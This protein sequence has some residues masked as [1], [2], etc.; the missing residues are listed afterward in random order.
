MKL[1]QNKL[2]CICGKKGQMFLIAAIFIIV[3][4]A[5]IKTS[6]N[7]YQLLEN[8]RYLESSLEKEEFQNFK[9]ELIKTVEYS[10]YQKEN[11]TRNTEEFIKFAKNSFKSRTI[12][13]NG[14]AVEAIYPK[15]YANTNTQ[16]NVTVFNFLG[17]EIKELNLTFNSSSQTFSL[18]DSS[19]H[20]VQFLFNTPSDYNYTLFVSFLTSTKNKTEEILIPVEINESKFVGFFDLEILSPRGQLKEKLEL[21]YYLI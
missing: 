21:S 5:L 2:F 8:K 19:S 6:F 17:E 10:I 11:I 9:E 7:I 4:L 14:L 18:P 13:L 16:L 1:S 3:I 15:V 20:S 12:D